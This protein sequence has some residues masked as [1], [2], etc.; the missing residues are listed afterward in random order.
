[1]ED[2]GSLDGEDD[3]FRQLLLYKSCSLWWYQHLDTISR[4]QDDPQYFKDPPPEMEDGGSLDG[5]D[6]HFRQRLLYK[7]CLQFHTLSSPLETLLWRQGFR[8]AGTTCDRGKSHQRHW[9]LR[10]SHHFQVYIQPLGLTLLTHSLVKSWFNFSLKLLLQPIRC[11]IG[12][13]PPMGG[14][15]TPGDDVQMSV[16]LLETYFVKQTLPEMVI[17]PIKTAPVLHL[18]W[19]ILGGRGSSWHLEMVSR[20]QYHY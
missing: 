17:F 10:R 19:W 7:S 12:L 11:F 6:D 16:S 1:M 9:S 2:G 15:L 20:C 8:R 13:Q 3:H 5:E 4:R 18:W 14:I